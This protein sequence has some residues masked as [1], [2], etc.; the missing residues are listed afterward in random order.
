ME[1]HSKIK[2]V[3]AFEVIIAGRISI[4]LENEDIKNKFL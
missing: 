4:I 3:S 1:M 2:L